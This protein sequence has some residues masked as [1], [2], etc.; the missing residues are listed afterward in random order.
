MSVRLSSNDIVFRSSVRE[1][2]AEAEES[3]AEWERFHKDKG[4][5]CHVVA[6]C[7]FCVHEGNP[8]NQAEDESCWTTREITRIVRH[9]NPIRRINCYF[10]ERLHHHPA[11]VFH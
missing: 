2:T 9:D 10:L 3:R 5:S 7:G 6:P 11:L 1:L 4:C 8:A